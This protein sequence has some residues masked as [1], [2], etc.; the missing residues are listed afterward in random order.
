M[1]YA[2]HESESTP[3]SDL[4]DKGSSLVFC[5]GES[6]TKDKGFQSF[7]KKK[8]KKRK[9]KRRLLASIS[10]EVGAKVFQKK[11]REKCFQF[12]SAL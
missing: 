4:S 6:N 2:R 8:K 3:I 1:A 5:K 11:E 10:K 9:R 7:K 12:M